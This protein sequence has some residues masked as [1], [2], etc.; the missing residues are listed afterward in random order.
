MVTERV[1]SGH[2]PFLSKPGETADFLRRAAG[3]KV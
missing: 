2:S 1:F 3:E